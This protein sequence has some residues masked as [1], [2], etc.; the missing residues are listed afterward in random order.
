V[1]VSLTNLFVLM[2]ENRSFDHMLGFSGIT[3]FDAETGTQTAVRGLMG[4]ESNSYRGQVYAVSRGADE[5]MPVDPGHEFLDVLEELSGTNA[6]Y[7]PGQAYPAID[8]SGFVSDYALSHTKDEGDA[9]GDYGEILS[10]FAPEQLPILNAL[11]REFA[12]CDNWHASMPGPTWPNRL[13][14]VA[15]SSDGLDHSPT[16][17]EILTWET[18]DGIEFK[19][20]T[21]FDALKRKSPNGFRIYSGDDFPL[22]ASLKGI[23]LVDIHKYDRFAADVANADYCWLLTWIE[24][25]YGDTASGTFKGGNSQHPMDGVTPGEA[26]IKATYEAI[27][28]SPHWNSSLLIIT[29]DEH[30]GFFDH[31]A[32]PAAIPPGDTAPLSKYNQYGFTFDQYGVRLPAIIVSPHIRK[33]VIDHRLYDHSSIPATVEEAFD[34][35][36]LTARDKA[37]NSAT[38]LLNLADPRTDTPATLPAT[39]APGP[40]A[41]RQNVP[42]LIAPSTAVTYR[43]SCMSLCVGTWRSRRLPSATR[44]SHVCRRFRRERRRRNTSMRFELKFKLPPDDYDFGDACVE[45]RNA[46]VRTILTIAVGPF[47]TQIALKQL[48]NC[49][50]WLPPMSPIILLSH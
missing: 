45:C 22:V 27:R 7:S 38:A 11:A 44:F 2:L 13:F 36:A 39:A 23:T 47:R 50:Q 1:P 9:P 29:W 28:N 35:P 4:T 34:V 17:A 5:T 37:A 16:T 30:G 21:I 31:A 46:F 24:P 49:R 3:G 12:V 14:S 18:V 25:N 6:A 48:K 40:Q 15:A 19:N 20:G 8:N 32:P 43:P 33:N 41:R 42:A 10:C 26:L